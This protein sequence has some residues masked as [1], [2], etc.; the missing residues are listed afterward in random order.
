MLVDIITWVVVLI[1]FGF[2]GVL[3]GKYVDGLYTLSVVCFLIV[4]IGFML[5][6]AIIP[7]RVAI[8][9]GS[10]SL[11]IALYSLYISFVVIFADIRNKTQVRAGKICLTIFFTFTSLFS[12]MYDYT[13][14]GRGL[15]MDVTLL[16]AIMTFIY[17]HCVYSYVSMVARR[18][19][20]KCRKHKAEHNL[21]I[22]HTDIAE[23]PSSEKND[24][25]A[26]IERY[27]VKSPFVT[28]ICATSACQ[29]WFILIKVWR[30]YEV[31]ANV[32]PWPSL[33]LYLIASVIDKMLRRVGFLFNFRCIVWLPTM[34]GA[35]A[36][37]LILLR[38]KT[39]ELRD[40]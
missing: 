26:V 17:M 31:F 30:L 29:L 19:V 8:A 14:I 35:T 20:V 12:F 5:Y 37:L 23:D 34:L 36:V 3:F 25:A 11:M 2:L 27:N 7:V 15:K 18:I 32:R 24:A 22:K 38:R 6:I 1:V 40:T 21:F 16:R 4:G 33:N 13:E 28:I 10:A 39:I 9:T